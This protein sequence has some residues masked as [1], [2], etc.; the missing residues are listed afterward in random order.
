MEWVGPC[1]LVGYDVNVIETLGSIT[2]A[3]VAEM[4]HYWQLQGIH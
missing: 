1:L 2:R 4:P 3:L